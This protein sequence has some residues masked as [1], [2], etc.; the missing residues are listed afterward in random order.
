MKVWDG[1]LDSIEDVG[2]YCLL[3]KKCNDCGKEIGNIIEPITDGSQD[4]VYLCF[5]CAKKSKGYI[6]ILEHPTEN[7]IAPASPMT[8]ELWA[9]FSAPRKEKK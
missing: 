2:P 9:K 3:E 7:N 8:D 1:F 6:N 5:A 4:I